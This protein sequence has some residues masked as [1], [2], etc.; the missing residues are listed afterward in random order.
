MTH[1][2]ADRRFEHCVAPKRMFEMAAR[3]AATMS[4]RLA[5]LDGASYGTAREAAGRPGGCC[6]DFTVLFVSLARAAG[7]P[8][9]VHVGFASYFILTPW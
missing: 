1:Y 7:I 2:R 8:A 5:D 3:Y 6:R 4:E 9:R